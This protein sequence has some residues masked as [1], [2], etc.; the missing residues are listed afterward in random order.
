MTAVVQMK[1]ISEALDDYDNI[2]DIADDLKQWYE[3]LSILGESLTQAFEDK[4]TKIMGKSSNL[5]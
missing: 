1:L 3:R 4:K 2:D 5:P